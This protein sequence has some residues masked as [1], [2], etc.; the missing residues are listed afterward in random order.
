MKI[1]KSYPSNYAIIRATLNPNKN[2]I[3]C[4]GDIIYN[5]SGEEIPEDVLFHESVHSAQQG[6]DIA[7]WWAR[8]V[9]DKDFRQEQEVQAFGA[10][11][12]FVKRKV[13]K[14]NI[15]GKHI[16]L[17]ECMDELANNLKDNYKLNLSFGEAESKIRNTAKR[18]L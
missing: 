11:Y 7:V 13:K 6:K 9:R 16:I 15:Q 4:W 1:I 2:T 18:M 8:Y 5:P 10:Q 17:K 14:L 3:Y 12:E